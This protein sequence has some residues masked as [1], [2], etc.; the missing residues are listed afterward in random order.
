MGAVTTGGTIDGREFS[1][2][3]FP[4]CLAPDLFGLES[5]GRRGFSLFSAGEVLPSVKVGRIKIS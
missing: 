4:V 3:L 5:L 1:E 2:T